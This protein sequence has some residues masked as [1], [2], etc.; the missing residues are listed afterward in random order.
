MAMEW[1]WVKGI[2]W[3]QALFSMLWYPFPVNAKPILQHLLDCPYTYQFLLEME[4]LDFNILSR[5]YTFK[6]LKVT[7]LLLREDIQICPQTPISFNKWLIRAWCIQ[8]YFGI[9]RKNE[10][11]ETVIACEEFLSEVLQINFSSFH[12]LRRA[13]LMHH[14]LFYTSFPYNKR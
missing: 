9:C 3:M 4:G 6:H 14:C 10:R 2:K 12:I 7:T 8:H 5:I 1:L 11:H 13:R